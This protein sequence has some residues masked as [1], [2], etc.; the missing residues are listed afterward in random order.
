VSRS[1]YRWAYRFAYHPGNHWVLEQQV[2][3]TLRHAVAP[4]EAVGEAADA[5]DELPALQPGLCVVHSG[6]EDVREVEP[7]FQPAELLPGP[8]QQQ[9]RPGLSPQEGVAAV[10][11]R[12]PCWDQLGEVVRALSD[13]PRQS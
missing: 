2:E 6:R 12:I 1:L 7:G 8:A 13:C 5:G 9:V 3:E 10:H 11:R 4:V